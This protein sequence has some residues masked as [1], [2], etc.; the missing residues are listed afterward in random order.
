MNISET[1][2][3]FKMIEGAYPDSKMVSLMGEIQ[4]EQIQI[5]TDSFS[6]ESYDTVNAALRRHISRSSYAPKI[7]DLR[8]EINRVKYP[9]RL[10]AWDQFE[11]ALNAYGVEKVCNHLIGKVLEAANKLQISKIARMDTN[12][13][14]TEFI[15]TYEEVLIK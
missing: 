9:T 5:W 7:A 6:E 13:A 11:R 15:K 4:D 3:I 14:K 10:E 12:E 8:N 2:R 1:A